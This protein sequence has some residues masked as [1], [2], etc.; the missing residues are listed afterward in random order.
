MWQKK[1]NKTIQIFSVLMLVVLLLSGCVTQQN[2]NVAQT[3]KEYTTSIFAMGTYMNLT[4]YGSSAN[5]ALKLSEKKIKELET[6][7]SVTDENSDIYKINQN[8]STPTEIN[9]ETA[10]IL[11][12]ALK[13]ANQTEGALDPTIYPLVTAWGFIS[14]EYH[15][16][17]ENEVIN[18]LQ[19][20]DYKKV[21]L[22]EKLV[23][24]P[25]G[26]QLDLGA[27]G[28]GYTGDIVTE[29]LKEQGVTSALLDIGGNIQMIGRKP[30]GS[31]WQL[32][33][34][35][36]FGEGTLG[37]LESEDGAV[38]TSG[39]YER[40]FIGEDGKRYGHILD[41]SS[42]YPAESG[43]AS[44][45]IVGKEGK[46]CDALSTAIYVMGLDKATKYWKENSGFEML[47][48]T[49]ENKIYLTEGIKDDFIKN[50]T[51]S[52]KDIFIIEK[53]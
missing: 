45:S 26:M 38:V 16:P 33:I 43:L 20:V 13:M 5:S 22:E 18:L 34:Q 11:R 39:N 23:T 32:G 27:V 12:F 25:D 15:L 29:L 17:T 50:D 1:S 4:A 51:L 31:K 41:P 9:E 35:N 28:K 42:G 2:N 46:M 7:W 52:D 19:K 40:Y 49:D 14:G 8:G 47:L 21:L 36:P 30:D 37:V 3:E 24:L 10:D 44:V 6:M 53:P 48:V